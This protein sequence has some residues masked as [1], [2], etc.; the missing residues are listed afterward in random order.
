MLYRVT[1]KLPLPFLMCN[2]KMNRGFIRSWQQV[3]IAAYFVRV[4][5]ILPPTFLSVFSLRLLKRFISLLPT[6][7]SS[8]GMMNKT[9]LFLCTKKDLGNRYDTAAKFW[10]VMVWRWF[11]Q[12][13]ITVQTG[14]SKWV[15]TV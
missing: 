10:Y 11:K 5:L 1:E 9:S 6:L 15:G 3:K 13:S 14:S 7:V 12:A 2:R 8:D 4:Y